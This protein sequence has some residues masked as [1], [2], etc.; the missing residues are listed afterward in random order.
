MGNAYNFTTSGA[1]TYTI[2]SSNL[3]HHVDA[4]GVPIEIRAS[5]QDAVVSSVS[6]TLA[7]VGP[8]LERR[9]TYQSCTAARQTLLVSAA[10]QAQSYA[11]SAYSY[12]SGVTSGT[13]RYVTWFG[14]YTAARRTTVLGHYQKISSNTFS[15]YTY[16]CSCTDSGTYA[17]LAW[18]TIVCPL[19]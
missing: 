12:I 6:G 13:T 16:D 5:V 19:T 4:S 18:L 17:R 2:E 1:G 15:S 11:S 10:S 8:A 9:A 14:T 3:F 7:V